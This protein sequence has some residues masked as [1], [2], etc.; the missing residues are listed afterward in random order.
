MSCATSNDGF[1]LLGFFPRHKRGHETFDPLARNR[2]RRAGRRQRHSRSEGERV[3]PVA[4]SARTRRESSRPTRDN[5]CR[6]LHL[7]RL[8]VRPTFVQLLQLSTAN[9]VGATDARHD[10]LCNFCATGTPRGAG[11]TRA[12]R[13]H[14]SPP[15]RATIGPLLS[16]DSSPCDRIRSAIRMSATAKSTSYPALCIPIAR[17]NLPPRFAIDRAMSIA[18]GHEV[19]LQCVPRCRSRR[20]PR[21]P[22]QL[23]DALLKATRTARTL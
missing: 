13:P 18:T 20:R 19:L 1:G 4:P 17:N 11:G 5:G 12:H 22:R 14:E 23:D 3:Q 9:P 2:V 6:H 16:A 10:P 21:R 15:H 8:P 7:T